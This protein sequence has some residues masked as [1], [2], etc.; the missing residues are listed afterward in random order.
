[1]KAHFLF[2][3]R[4]PAIGTESAERPV[5]PSNQNPPHRFTG[6]MDD[7]PARKRKIANPTMLSGAYYLNVSKRLRD[8]YCGEKGEKFI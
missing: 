8:C 1:M 2:S 6:G 5:F 7:L 4:I 3:A